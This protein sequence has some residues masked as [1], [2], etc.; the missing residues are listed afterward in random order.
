MPPILTTKAIIL[1]PHGGLG[2]SIPTDPRW[3][4]DGG[5]VL[6]DGDAGT[7]ACP[8]LL[9]PCV[10][11]RLQSMGLNATRIGARPVMLV[12][13]F[14][15]SFTGFPLTLTEVHQV[16]DDSTPA[17]IPPGASAPPLSPELADVTS[18]VVT[19]VMPLTTVKKV[20]PPPAGVR[21]TFSLTSPFPRTWILTWQD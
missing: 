1:C 13:D 14:T 15:Q 12:T 10:G 3:S 16:V 18:P 20:P 19:V 7:L 21:M 17:P 8:F 4:I 9:F 5:T 6:L 11:Y 2:T